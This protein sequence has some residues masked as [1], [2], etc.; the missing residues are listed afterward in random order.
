[1]LRETRYATSMNRR[2]AEPSHDATFKHNYAKE[3]RN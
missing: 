2:R 1:M 3:L